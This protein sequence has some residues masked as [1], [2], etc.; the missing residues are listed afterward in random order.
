M[1]STFVN[2]ETGFTV[3]SLDV[4]FRAAQGGSI[5]FLTRSTT[6]LTLKKNKKVPSY[7]FVPNSSDKTARD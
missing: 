2:T 1:E 7:L 4:F 5:V 3:F 6:P